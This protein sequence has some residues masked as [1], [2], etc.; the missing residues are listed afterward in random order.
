MQWSRADEL[1]WSPFGAAMAIELEADLDAA[2][3]I[4]GWRHE[5]W[6]NGHTSR[7]GRAKTPALL[8]AW[9]RENPSER[10]IAIN[11]PLANGGGADR[12]A[13]P[14]YDFPAYRV[15]NHRLLEM[16]LRTSALR[17]LGAFANVFAIESFLDE[18]AAGRGEDPVKLRLRHLSD[19]RAKGGDRGGCGARRLGRLAA[20]RRLRARHRLCALQEFRRVLRGGGRSRGRQRDPRAAAGDR[21]R[22]GA[23]GQSGRRREP[24]RRRRGAGGEL[25][26]EGGGALRSHARDQR[27]VGN[28]PDPALLRGSGGRG[29]DPRPAGRGFERRGRGGAGPYRGRDRQRGVRCARRARARSADHRR[30]HRRGKV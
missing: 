10:L 26:P 23:G 25:D 22:R 28:L 6:S 8:A 30:A 21:R 19:A 3:A 13:V 4:V 24:D 18:I 7:P 17:S 12:N 14:L 29:R 11:P 20:P 27:C 9:H 1:A 5:L 2:G 15:V 16:P